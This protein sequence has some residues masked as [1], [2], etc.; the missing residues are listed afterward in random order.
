VTW[1]KEHTLDGS[2][3]AATERDQLLPEVRETAIH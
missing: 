1:N 2:D 3:A